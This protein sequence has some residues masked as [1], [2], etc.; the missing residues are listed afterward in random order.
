MGTYK[1]VNRIFDSIPEGK[2]KVDSLRLR[3]MEN[4]GKGL[5]ILQLKIWRQKA[6]CRMN[7]SSL[8]SQ[9]SQKAVIPRTK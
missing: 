9:I 6:M 5:K 7:I 8:K 1:V 3:R 4:V 2:R